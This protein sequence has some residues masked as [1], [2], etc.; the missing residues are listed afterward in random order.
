M[1]NGLKPE[2]VVVTVTLLRGLKLTIDEVHELMK[3]KLGEADLS[4]DLKRYEKGEFFFAAYR[5]S[6]E[7]QT[8]GFFLVAVPRK[9]NLKVIVSANGYRDLPLDENPRNGLFAN[10]GEIKL[11]PPMSPP[12]APPIW[13]P[14][15]RPGRS[16]L[17]PPL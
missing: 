4:A 3:V 15:R 9:Q 12:A 6:A 13:D 17:V 5:T 10:V 2:E 14:R 7:S 1:S 11:Y 16:P 8:D